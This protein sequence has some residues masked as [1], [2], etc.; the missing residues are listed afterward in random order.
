MAGRA[1]VRSTSPL[2][3][4]PSSR[5]A[6]PTQPPGA[7]IPG[8]R[9]C[10]HALLGPCGAPMRLP[11]ASSWLLTVGLGRGIVLGWWLVVAL[12]HFEVGMQ[13]HVEG[14]PHRRRV[15]PTGGRQLLRVGYI[16]VGGQA[17]HRGSTLLAPDQGCSISREGAPIPAHASNAAVSFCRSCWQGP[18]HLAPAAFGRD[19]HPAGRGASTA[20]PG[21][22][23]CRRQVWRIRSSPGRGAAAGTGAAP[24]RGMPRDA[25]AP[26]GVYGVRTSLFIDGVRDRRDNN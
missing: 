25:K 22:T 13:C 23:R 3:S 24:G 9:S 15:A 4:A 26:F 17:A 19:T 6:A 16:L 21:A 8:L 1:G 10:P 7:F 5:P 12:A 20:S 18:A 2:R 11:T 14:L